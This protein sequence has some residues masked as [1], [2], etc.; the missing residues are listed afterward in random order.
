MSTIRTW[1]TFLTSRIR[2]WVKSTGPP[3]ELVRSRKGSGAGTVGTRSHS[4]WPEDVQASANP[5]STYSRPGPR[6]INIGSD[7]PIV[8]QL[9]QSRKPCCPYQTGSTSMFVPP[10]KKTS[11][12]KYGERLYSDL[13]GL[14]TTKLESLQ[15]LGD[16]PKSREQGEISCRS[17]S[18]PPISS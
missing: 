3:T 17:T 12:L 1:S 5:A 13:Q 7:A 18:P 6:D 16:D 2:G 10:V 8:E 15:R 11:P 4:T 14:R 9:C